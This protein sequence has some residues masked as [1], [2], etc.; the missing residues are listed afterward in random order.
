MKKSKKYI[1]MILQKQYIFTYYKNICYKN[2]IK[3]DTEFWEEFLTL[4]LV[5]IFPDIIYKNREERDF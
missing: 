3:Y 4:D 2:Y 1:Y 5:R